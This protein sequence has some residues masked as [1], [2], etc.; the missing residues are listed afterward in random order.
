MKKITLA[1]MLLASTGLVAQEKVETI[2]PKSKLEKWSVRAEYF[3]PKSIAS[4]A[5]ATKNGYHFPQNFGFKIGV[6]R[7]GKIT[8]KGKIY[9]FANYGF[10][11]D[12]YFERVSILEVGIGFQRNIVKGLYIA[13]EINVGYNYA[14]SSHLS[15]KL[16]NDVWV[17]SVDKS[18]V[19]NRVQLGINGYVGYDFAKHLNAKI[20][21]TLFVGYGAN[22]INNYDKLNQIKVFAY[23]Q[24]YVGIKW[25]L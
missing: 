11:N 3:R 13:S 20:P 8:N 18:T 7:N 5:N 2:V 22:G 25:K 4:F 1:I 12:V 16:V 6:E 9:Q 21:A 17:E 24:P 15:S 14:R 10:Y 23:H 19:H